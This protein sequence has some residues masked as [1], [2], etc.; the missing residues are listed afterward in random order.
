[1]VLAIEKL[2]KKFVKT[3]RF[4]EIVLKMWQSV[5]IGP[6][7]EPEPEPYH[8]GSATLPLTYI[9]KKYSTT[10]INYAGKLY[11]EYVKLTQRIKESS[12]RIF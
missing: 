10:L 1:V 8:L 3:L 7:L 5:Y 4:F 2:Q 6:D 11:F 9:G 12:R